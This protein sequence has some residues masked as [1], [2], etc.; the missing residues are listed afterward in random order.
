VSVYLAARGVKLIGP[1]DQ[2]DQAEQIIFIHIARLQQAVNFLRLDE[3][4]S[5][6]LALGAAPEQ[7]VYRSQNQLARQALSVEL[8]TRPHF[9]LHHAHAP[10]VEFLAQFYQ[11]VEDHRVLVQVRVSVDVREAE[12]RRGEPFELRPHLA[13]KFAS[14][15]GAEIVMNAGAE[16]AGRE[17]T[18]RI[19]DVR[20]F[21]VGQCG[22]ALNQRQVKSDG[23]GRIRSRQLDGVRGGALVDHQTAA[24]QDTF[25]MRQDDRAV[26]GLGIAEIVAADD[27][28]NHVMIGDLGVIETCFHRRFIHDFD[29]GATVSTARGKSRSVMP[30][31]NAAIRRLISSLE[32]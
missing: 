5:A 15:G 16:R 18:I 27:Q 13:A 7:V 26:D 31:A 12:S 4:S 9:A 30:G 20:D 14:R 21:G 23:E 24:R 25:A 11:L 3:A 28:R 22:A 8:Q 19:G 1:P 10:N 2:S 29:G 17:I 6:H 32:F